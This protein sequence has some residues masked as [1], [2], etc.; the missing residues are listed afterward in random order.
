MKGKGNKNSNT[1][2]A[3]VSMFHVLQLNDNLLVPYLVLSLIH[4]LMVNYELIRS[5]INV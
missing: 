2:S 4:I 3:Y 5:L 1:S